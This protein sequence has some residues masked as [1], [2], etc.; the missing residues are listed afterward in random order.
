[1]EA[2]EIQIETAQA[3]DSKP[4]RRLVCASYSPSSFYEAPLPEENSRAAKAV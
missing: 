2:T 1:M 3:V 4:G